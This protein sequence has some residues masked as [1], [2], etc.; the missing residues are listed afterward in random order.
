MI[1]SLI[2]N[3]NNLLQPYLEFNYLIVKVAAFS[4]LL[5]TV[6]LLKII[7]DSIIGL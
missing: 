5:C 6:H 2:D 1:S 4:L 7:F 3:D